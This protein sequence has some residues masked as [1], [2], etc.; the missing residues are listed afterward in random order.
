MTHL[1]DS[2]VLIALAVGD[3]VHHRAAIRWWTGT[4]ERFATCPITQGALVRLLVRE[5]LGGEDAARALGLLTGHSRH[6]FWPDS[7]G[8][9]EVD[10]THVLGHGQVTDAYLASLA[11]RQGGRL[12]TFDRGLAERAADVVTLVPL[13]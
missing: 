10:L 7:M 4:D 11:R 6:A 2:N 5:G 8:Y 13:E 12:A 1:L 3:H 9:E